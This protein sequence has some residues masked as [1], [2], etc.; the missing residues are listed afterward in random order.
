MNGCRWSTSPVVVGGDVHANCVADLK[1]DFDDPRSAVIATEFCGTSI[2]SLG[3][4]Q[5]QVDAALRHNPHV[6]WGRSDQRG[7]VR[8]TLQRGELQAQLRVVADAR[9]AVSAVATAAQF[10]V[11]AGRPGA[12]RG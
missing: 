2:S 10:A 12:V 8:F 6:H 5:A 11:Q 4:P 3:L 1:A 7:S 9:D